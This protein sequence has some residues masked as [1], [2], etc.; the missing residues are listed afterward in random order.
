MSKVGKRLINLPSGVEVKSEETQGRGKLVVIKGPKGQLSINIDP[1]F[2][3]VLEDKKVGLS[4]ASDKE[5]GFELKALWG[6][7]RALLNN[8]VIGVSAGFEKKLE[9]EGVGYRA[10]IA[11]GKLVLN[12]GFSHPVEVII[13]QG[14][15]VKVEKNV[16]T[17]FGID[18]HLLGQF[19]AN[20]RGLKPPEPYK[21]KGIRYQ[22]EVI[23]RKAGKKAASAA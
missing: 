19:A 22:G 18:K 2:K 14:I 8:S 10:S 12:I 20:V 9:L 21:G 4:P 15:E 3:L 13:P 17:I 6:L 16:I 1:R 5:L 7:Q 11:Q 23:R